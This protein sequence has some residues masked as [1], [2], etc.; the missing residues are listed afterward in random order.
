MWCYRRILKIPWADRVSNEEV[1][2]R[3]EEERPCLRY[4]ILE[5][6]EEGKNA[7]GTPS[8][9]YTKLSVYVV[10]KELAVF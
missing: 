7:R 10:R 3:I 2:L 5:G 9:N 4:T 1:L 6:A 8:T